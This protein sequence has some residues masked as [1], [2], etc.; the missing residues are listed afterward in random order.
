M[1]HFTFA[2]YS[3]FAGTKDAVCN[4][5]EQNIHQKKSWGKSCV[6]QLENCTKTLLWEVTQ[7]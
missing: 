1:I 3:A 5:H 2:L 6:A 4:V 7:W